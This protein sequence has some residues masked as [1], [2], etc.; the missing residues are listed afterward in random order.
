MKK[1]ETIKILTEIYRNA[2]LSQRKLAEDLGFSLGKLNYSLKTLQNQGLIKF[3]KNSTNSKKSNKIKYEITN[4]VNFL[5]EISEKE[6]NYIDEVD[7]VNRKRTF[8]IAEIG[9]NHNGSVTEA[10]QLIKLAKKFDFD[11][12]KFQKRDLNICIPEHQKKITRETPW[13]NITYFDYK[14]KN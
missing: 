10:K 5:E 9:I 14:K 13:G 7:Q 6:N 8:L 4:K 11:A 2:N 1:K 3:K 12:V